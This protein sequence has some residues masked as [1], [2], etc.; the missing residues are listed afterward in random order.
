MQLLLVVGTI[1]LIVFIIVLI[2]MIV[3]IFK[4]TKLIEDTREQITEQ[5]KQ[6]GETLEKVDSLIVDINKF[7]RQASV[8]LEKIDNMADGIQVFITKVDSK[9]NNLV[10]SMSDVGNVMRN[11]IFSIERVIS[12]ITN[13]GDFASKIRSF[14]PSRKSKQNN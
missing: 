4:S 1:A 6:F 8:S 14:F 9:A 5:S 2:Y 11:T 12:F 10:E 3:F 7:V 13:I